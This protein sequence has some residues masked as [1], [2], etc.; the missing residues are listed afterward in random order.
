MDIL[1]SLYPVPTQ[2]TLFDAV[3]FQE[4]YHEN[5]FALDDAYL[6]PFYQHMKYLYVQHMEK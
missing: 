3:E 2:Y 5:P 4:R 1:S 6:T